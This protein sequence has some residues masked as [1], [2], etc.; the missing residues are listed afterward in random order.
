MGSLRSFWCCLVVVTVS[1]QISQGHI[2]YVTPGPESECPRDGSECQTLDWYNQNSNGS[3]MTNNTEVRFLEGVHKLTTS[4]AKVK[5]LY[6]VT[7]TGFRS[8]SSLHKNGN[9]GIKQPNSIID[10]RA[11][12]PSGFVFVNSS[13]IYLKNIGFESCGE[14]I[15]LCSDNHTNSTATLSFQHGSNIKLHRVTVNNTRGFGLHTSNVFGSISITESAFLRSKGKKSGPAIGNARFW[16]GY[17]CGEQCSDVSITHLNVTSSQFLDGRGNANGLEVII[18]CPSVYVVIENTTIGNNRGKHGG[19]IALSVTDLGVPLNE[20]II[21]ISN[22]RIEKGIAKRGGGLRFWS[23][24]EQRNASICT[25]T[26]IHRVLDIYNTTFRSNFASSTGGALYMVHYQSGGFDCIVKKIIFTL[27][28]FEHNFGNGAVMEITKHLILADHASPQLNVSFD[29][30]TFFNN[31][32]SSHRAIANGPVMSFIMTYIAMANCIIAG[33]NGTAVSL[34]NSNLN[35]YDSVR[36]ENNHAKY[37]GAL[38]VCERSFIFLHNNSHIQFINNTALMGGA[39]FIQQSYLE[40]ASPCAFQPALP[41]AIPIKEFHKYLKLE[42]VNNSASTAGDVIYGGSLT[43]CYTIGSYSYYHP[44]NKLKSFFNFKMIFNEIFNTKAQ[45]G[46]SPVS[47]YPLGVCF[48]D[49]TKSELT[50]ECQTDH[51]PLEVYPGEEFTVSAKTIGQLNGSTIGTIQ[52]SLEE[53]SHFHQLTVLNGGK[54]SNQCIPLSFSVLSNESIATIILKPS[55]ERYTKPFTVNVT[56]HLLPCPLG[57]ELINYTGGQYKCDCS[58][59]FHHHLG[60]FLRPIECDITTQTIRKNA[61]VWFGCYDGENHSVMNNSSFC[62]TPVVSGTCVYY[63]STTNSSGNISIY[64]L[65]KQCIR[66]RTGVLCGACKPGL[67]HILGLSHECRKCSDKK[68]FIYI[69]SVLFSGVLT[70]FLLTVLNLTIT[71]GT[72]NGLML[73]ATFLFTCRDYFFESTDSIIQ[74]RFSKAF[75]IFI[76]WLNLDSG[77]DACAYDGLTGYQYIWLTFGFVFYL[78]IIQAVMII[79]SHK[80]IFF[81]RLFGRNVLKVLATLLVLTHSQLMYACFH[82]LLYSHLIISTSTGKKIVNVWSFDGNIPYFGLKHMVLFLLAVICLLFMLFFTL[83]L[84]FIQC[85]QKHNNR[86]YLRWVERLRPFFEAFTGPCHNE[87]RFWPGLL[88]L[89]RT[90]IYALSMYFNGYESY[91]RHWKMLTISAFCVLV[92][93]LACI[94]PRGVY[95]KWPLNVLEF[96]YFLNLCILCVFLAYFKFPNRPIFVSVSLVMVTF[97]GLL[98]YHTYRQ[99]KATKRWNKITHWISIYSQRCRKR[100]YS[101]KLSEECDPLLPQSLPAVARFQ[102]YREPLLDDD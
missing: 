1:L 17:Q 45:I 2:I 39:I 35:L 25:D 68:L 87:Y 75:W 61:P 40:T 71:E 96:S 79:L 84:L 52:P 55:V 82:S 99:I 23:R 100:R 47:S 64:D 10:C 8:S 86:W 54:Y 59:L 32:M 77:F 11:S 88:H 13:E 80:F 95:K 101:S 63:C 41:E 37:G 26:N 83:C 70:V 29:N 3:F 69:P 43:T 15:P 20:P 85:L 5:N 76:A 49:P 36:F 102:A 66:G 65:D 18:G 46:P 93:T 19:N 56:V 30:C 38:K 42:F 34:Y 24:T 78:L 53:E 48:C 92:M 6:N 31:S 14:W 27:C 60:V 94:F 28:K 22:S 50:P 73:Y 72:V 7:I 89:I 91:Y 67:S 97:F 44:R 16:F 4:I 33:S 74:H 62:E 90:L 12:T 9:E 98:L 21:K 57:F 58:S 81:T 51:Q